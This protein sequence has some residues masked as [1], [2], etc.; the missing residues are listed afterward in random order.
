MNDSAQVGA[1]VNNTT[2][3]PL[4]A[5]VSLRAAGL[6]A[7]VVTPA[8]AV[9]I[10]AGGE[11]LV[12]WPMQPRALGTARLVPEPS[13]RPAWPATAW[14]RARRSSPTARRRWWPRP[15]RSAASRVEQVAVPAAAQPG[16]GGLTLTLQPS[17]A[18][19]L[20]SSVDYLQHYPM[21]R[22]KMWPRDSWAR[23]R[24][25]GCLRP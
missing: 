24:W 14:S 18:A 12:T 15:A 5:R 16:E 6:G 8:T 13:A 2:D 25:R 17:L 1:V 22:T 4:L 21:S 10:P 20:R 9:T 11:Q 3:R 7:P 23:S 19:G